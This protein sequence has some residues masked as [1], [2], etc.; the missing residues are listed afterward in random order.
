MTRKADF[1]AEEWQHVVEGP[2]SAGL[3]VA[4]AD[5][6]GTLRESLSLA[7]AYQHAREQ[8][9]R[10]EL[11]DDLISSPPQLDPREFGSPDQ[12]RERALQRLREAVELVESKANPDEAAEYKRFVMSLADTVAHAHREGG[13]LGIGGKEV[14]ESEQAALDEIAATVGSTSD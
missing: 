7:R 6:G 14:S 8:S 10:P 12:L 9:S 2:L 3:L 1:N 11:L 4:A 5:R 13:V